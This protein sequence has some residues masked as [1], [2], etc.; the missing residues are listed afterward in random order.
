[1]KHHANILRA[2]PTRRHLLRSMAAVGVAAPFAGGLSSPALAQQRKIKIAILSSIS[3]PRAGFAECS[4]WMR[5]R[6]AS[7]FADGLTI[8]GQ[9]YE[10]EFILKDTQTSADRA[11][12][13]GKDLVLRDQVDMVL[14]DDP[15]SHYTV[16]PLC[17]QMGIPYVTTMISW[18][19]FLDTRGSNPEKGFP[20]SFDFF[21][22]GPDLGATFVA[23][24]EKVK[25]SKIFGDTYV[26]HPTS[27][28]FS[29]IKTGIPGQAIAKGYT[30]S[31]GGWFKLD[32]D[33]FSTQ[34]NAWKRDDVSILT[35]FVYPPHFA[36]LHNQAAQLGLRPD[37][38]SMAGAFLFPSGLEAVGETADGMS[39][40]VWWTP[41]VPFTSSINGETAR[42]VADAYTAETGRQWTQPIGYVH[43][44]YEVGIAALKNS[45]DPK[46]PE[47]IRDA[48]RN[49]NLDTLVGPVNFRDSKIANVAATQIAMGQWRRTQ[50]GPFP[51]DLYITDNTLA[52]DIVPERELVLLSELG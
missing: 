40:E 31:D 18:D 38:V 4:E 43:S 2:R 3:G 9:T 16:A 24:W 14:A 30:R 29:D 10:I 46:N 1:M 48:L 39:T 23:Q 37:V 27:V 8:D 28:G 25:T 19:Q 21:W 33:D 35:G 49:M 15:D 5:D 32:T 51:F 7:Q 50:D 41:A 20:W 12:S 52:P 47:A 36:I 26:D 13:L 17:D 22:S 6:V 44:L 42:E 34:I 11:G 45:G